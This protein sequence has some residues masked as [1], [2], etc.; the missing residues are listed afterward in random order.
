MASERRKA[1]SVSAP[2]ISPRMNALQA[3]SA[4]Y[5]LPSGGLQASGRPG[6]PLAKETPAAL[7]KAVT[8]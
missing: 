3:L 5:T 4:Q 1:S 2:A 6:G 7:S 8:K